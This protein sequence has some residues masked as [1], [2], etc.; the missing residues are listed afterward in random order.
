MCYLSRQYQVSW[1]AKRLSSSVLL[2]LYFRVVKGK[3]EYYCTV[4]LSRIHSEYQ[5]MSSV[6]EEISLHHQSK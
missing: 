2:H 3:E 6:Q 5:Y 1:E 4:L